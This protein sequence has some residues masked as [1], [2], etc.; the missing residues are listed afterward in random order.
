MHPLTGDTFFIKRNYEK[1]DSMASWSTRSHSSSA[2]VGPYSVGNPFLCTVDNIM[3][4]LSLCSC[5]DVGNI[6]AGW[7]SSINF[8]LRKG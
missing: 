3:A 8:I 2:K 5:A 6:G 7:S 4:A 1:T